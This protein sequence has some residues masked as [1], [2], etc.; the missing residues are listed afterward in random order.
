MIAYFLLQKKNIFR[1]LLPRSSLRSSCQFR[2][3]GA[4]KGRPRLRAHTLPSMAFSSRKGSGKWRKGPL[5]QSLSSQQPSLSGRARAHKLLLSAPNSQVISAKCLLLPPSSLRLGRRRR[6]L[7]W[8][9]GEHYRKAKL[10]LSLSSYAE[11]EDLATL[12]NN[13]GLCSRRAWS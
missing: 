10:S 6:R 3:E 7:P 2:T 12:G 1:F 9:P 5:Q 8:V 13:I 4:I 11:E